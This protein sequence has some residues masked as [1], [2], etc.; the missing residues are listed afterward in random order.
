MNE[1]AIISI[2]KSDSP[3]NFFLIQLV[4]SFQHNS[5]ISLQIVIL[6]NQIIFVIFHYVL[7]DQNY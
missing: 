1:G 7:D 2:L 4:L 5:D 3:Q 6:H